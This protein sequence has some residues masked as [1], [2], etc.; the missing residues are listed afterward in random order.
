VKEIVDL[1]DSK[2]L[3]LD[4]KR[5][6]ES[7]W[8]EHIPFGMLL[9]E[10]QRPKEIV[11]LGTSSG[12]SYCAMCQAV[13]ELGYAARCYAVDTWA[14]DAHAGFYGE[15]IYNDLK[16]HHQ[17]YASFSQLLRM[18]FDDALK[19]IPDRSID[20]LHIDGFHTYDAVKAD[21]MNW[22]PKMSDRGVILFHDTAVRDRD[23]G[24]HKLWAE[25]SDQFP[26]FAF[27]HSYGLGV[28]AV[29][30]NQ[31]PG[32]TGFLEVATRFPS[33]IRNLFSSL[34]ARVSLR[35]EVEELRSE[36]RAVRSSR[37]YRWGGRLIWPLRMIKSALRGTNSATPNP[38]Q[39]PNGASSSA[40]LYISQ[41]PQ[42]NG[43]KSG[44]RTS[45]R[46][47]KAP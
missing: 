4:P 34:G 29:G 42:N 43:R 23:F 38:E 19:I 15:Y 33:G 18:P 1:L 16:A 9:V 10:L 14:G 21:Y 30:R 41:G 35:R 25:L 11:E 2:L 8:V 12:V 47:T 20:L 40:P 26:N 24:V 32:V 22:L 31:S 3:Y 46:G 27:E 44:A 37:D 6:I 7:A 28:L 39:G 36:L 17:Q 13:A 5:L 45:A